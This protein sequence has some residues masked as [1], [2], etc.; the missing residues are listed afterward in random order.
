MAHN[1]GVIRVFCVAIHE[2]SSGI[3]AI[4]KQLAT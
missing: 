3:M 4:D 2:K 1:I